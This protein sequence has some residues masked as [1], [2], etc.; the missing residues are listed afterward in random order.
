MAEGRTAWPKVEDDWFVEPPAATHFLLTFEYFTGGIW[1]PACGQGNIVEAC[2]LD[3]HDA[4]GSDL[5]DRLTKYDQAHLGPRYPI[6]GSCPSWFLGTMDFLQHP[7]EGPYRPNIVCNAPYG[8]AKL[9]EAVIRK[10]VT[11]PGVQKAAFFVNS[12]FLFGAGR[13]MGLFRDHPPHRVYPVFPRPS[14]PPGQFLLDG[15]KAEGGVENFVWLVFAPAEPFSGTEF[16][17]AGRGS[18]DAPVH[19]ISPGAP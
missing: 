17:W 11:L 1:D 10:A 2:L 13:A 7:L 4:V 16:I 5:R 14:C 3:G 6:Q 19:H 8:R 12:K 9:A 18:S 15:G